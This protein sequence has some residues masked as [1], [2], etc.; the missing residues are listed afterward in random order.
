MSLM[1]SSSFCES[2]SEASNP[3]SVYTIVDSSQ[4]DIQRGNNKGTAAA[5][6][7]MPSSKP[8][9]RTLVACRQLLDGDEVASL[10][11]QS[12]LP[13]LTL[14]G[15]LSAD[16]KGKASLHAS[17]TAE[18]SVSAAQQDKA[19]T[20]SRKPSIISTEGTRSQYYKELCLQVEERK[21]QQQ[22]ERRRNAA[23]D[24][25]HIETMLNSTWG[26]PGS[27]APNYHRGTAKRTMSLYRAGIL[28]QEQI[29]DKVLRGVPFHRL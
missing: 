25:K 26:M 14:T 20:S 8:K 4:K 3:G 7:Q 28:P 17:I 15:T 13:L 5:Q 6:T 23:D 19:D 9:A 27:G 22:K 12:P 24:Q 1:L 21:Q 18:A 2:D 29:R 11:N 16:P 10:S